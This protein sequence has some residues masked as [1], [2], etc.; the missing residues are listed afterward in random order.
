M[1]AA[2]GR[3]WRFYDPTTGVM[4]RREFIGPR[5][6]VAQ[7]T[8]AGYASIPG[9]FDPLSQRVDI[10]VQPPIV[11]AP[12]ESQ[13]PVDP[14]HWWPPVIDYIPPAPADDQWQTWAWD[15]A[16][17]RWAATPTL[18][19][20]KRNAT[21]R[22]AQAWNAAR[23]AGVSIGTKTAPTDADSWTRYLAIKAMAADGGWVDVPI[24]LLDG[25]F[26][27]LTQAKA[28]A[29]WAALKDM[30]RTLLV[31]LRDRVQDI[32]AATTQAQVE[33]VTW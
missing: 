31:R 3:Q 23:A 6:L 26:E 12:D 25:S 10:S 8:P 17:K 11:P 1:S 13:G 24:P 14:T 18:A 2:I 19:A 15:A 22:M 20:H 29:L 33:A 27:L 16:I 28:A 7:N 4:L 5:R 30:E 21:Q 32:N 9:N